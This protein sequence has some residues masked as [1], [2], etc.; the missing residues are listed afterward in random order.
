[1]EPM[2]R[3]KNEKKAS[4]QEESAG[5]FHAAFAGLAALRE[6]LPEGSRADPPMSQTTTPSSNARTKK[7]I[8][9]TRERKG[10]GGKTATRIAGLEAHHLDTLK[11]VLG[12]GGA[13]EEGDIV[14]HGDQTKRAASWL[15]DHGYA[16][17][18]IGN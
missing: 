14:L 8:V 7:K 10:R 16:N 5:P 13:L 6:N 2:G 15:K 9:L 3:T 17:V 1:M 12:C 4:T 18:V 11:R